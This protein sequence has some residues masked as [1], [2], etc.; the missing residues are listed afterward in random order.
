MCLLEVNVTVGIHPFT[1]CVRNDIVNDVSML[2]I[3]N[4]DIPS[5]SFDDCFRWMVLILFS[6]DCFHWPILILF[7]KYVPGSEVP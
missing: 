2:S 5:T 4:S 6:N 3:S 1:I 7:S